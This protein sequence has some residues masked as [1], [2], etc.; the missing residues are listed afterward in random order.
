M[1]GPK[2]IWSHHGPWNIAVSIA[3]RMCLV[4]LDREHL[5]I[6][7]SRLVVAIGRGAAAGTVESAGVT[8]AVS[9]AKRSRAT[10]HDS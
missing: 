6:A 1:S 7:E 9:R 3:C 5:D 8:A 2:R 10:T 4:R